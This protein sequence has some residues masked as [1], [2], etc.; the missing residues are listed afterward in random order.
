MSKNVNKKFSDKEYILT[1]V[2][3][4]LPIPQP[5]SNCNLKFIFIDYWRFVKEKLSG[6]KQKAY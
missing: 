4:S 5:C 2:G 6:I 1:K 3:C